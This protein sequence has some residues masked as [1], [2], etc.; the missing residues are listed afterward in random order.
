MKTIVG[1]GNPGKKYELTRHNIGFR[2]IDS[3]AEKHKLFF[4][5]SKNE[6]YY[7]CGTMGTSRFL[8]IKPTTFVNQSGIAVLD[9]VEEFNT[10]LHDLLIVVDDVNLEPGRIRIRKSGSDGG[11][12]GLKSIIYHLQTDNFPRLRFGIGS[13]F[14]K[15]ELADYVLSKF[16][17]KQNKVIEKYIS[18]ALE[19]IEEFI[20]NGTH[21]MLDYY[22]KY[23]KD[24]YKQANN[25]N[26]DVN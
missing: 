8:L 18:F 2:I 15:G 4:K 21:K 20:K 23:S 22:S 6:Y 11:H 1:I 17:K 26:P 9:S 7:A 5:P 19:L 3:F 13:D 25:I 10:S 12:N 16:D 14:E 24:I